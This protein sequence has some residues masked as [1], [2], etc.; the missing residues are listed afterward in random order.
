MRLHDE[1]ESRSVRI[2]FARFKTRT[3]RLMHASGL[4]DRI[5]SASFYLR[6]EDAV[7]AY[8]DSAASP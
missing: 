8:E 6:V 7:R 2:T 4:E 1:L 5:G 3:R